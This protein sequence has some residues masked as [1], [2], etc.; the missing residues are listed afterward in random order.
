MEAAAPATATATAGEAVRGLI[1]IRCTV[2]IQAP[3][4]KG[5]VTL[6]FIVNVI[7]IVMPI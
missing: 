7:V 5:I 3:K 2:A 6:G 4:Q 1:I